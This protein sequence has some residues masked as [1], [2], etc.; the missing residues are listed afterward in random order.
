MYH[1]KSPRTGFTLIELLVVIAIISILASILFPVFA[2]ARENARRASCLSNL[3]QIG[4]GVM[5]YTQ[6]YDEHYPLSLWQVGGLSGTTNQVQS[7]RVPGTPAAEFGGSGT[8]TFMDFIFP[9]VKSLQLFECPSFNNPYPTSTSWKNPP[10]YSYNTF[11][12]GYRQ[13][14]SSYP[15]YPPLSMAAIPRAAETVMI[16]DGPQAIH[17]TP[18]G[19]CSISSTGFQNPSRLPYYNMVFPHFE[20][21]NVTFADGHAKWYKRGSRTVCDHISATYSYNMANWPWNPALQN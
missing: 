18:G 2:R 14:A 15:S 1:R 4:L 19:Y 11:L 20:G 3:K 17:A 13:G 10:S 21:G 6:D 7:P 9:Y 16:L 8:Y 5:M 12:S